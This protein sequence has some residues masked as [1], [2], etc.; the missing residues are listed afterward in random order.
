VTDDRLLG[1]LDLAATLQAGRP[2]S[3]PGLLAEADGGVVVLPMAERLTA[4]MAA[5]LGAVLD[6]REVASERDGIAVRS[7]VRIG[8]LLFDEGIGE[9]ERAPAA[10]LDRL[11]FIV[12]L[13][14]VSVRNVVDSSYRL[15]DVAAARARLASVDG[16]ET[17]AEALCATAMALGIA[18]LRPPLLALRVARAAAALAGRST[19][20][21][22]DAAL[23]GR[24]V[25]APRALLPPAAEPPA[26]TDSDHPPP[27]EQSLESTRQPDSAEERSP[28][29]DKPLAEVVLEAAQ[30]AIPA[31]LLA[32]LRLPEGRRSPARSE[33]RAG[34]LRHSL[35]RGRPLGARRGEPKPGVRL[36]VVETLRAAA[37]WQPL[38]R[39]EG[40]GKRTARIE[41]RRD[42]FRVTRFKQRTETTAVFL[43][44]ASGSA[45][46]HRLAEAKGA[47]ELLLADCYVRRDQV[48]LLAF[49]GR[50]AEL[51]LPPTRSLVRAKRCLAALPGGGGTPL[52]AGIEAAAALAD[53]IRRRGDTPLMILLTDGR[54]N[55]ARDGDA[56]RVRAEQD[57]LSAARRVRAA[58]FMAVLVDTSPRPRPGAERLAAEMGA[59]YLALPHADAAMLSQ[60]VRA[61]VG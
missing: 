35:K 38:R 23:A 17:I 33:G 49:R 50:G 18:S 32:Q 60:A 61:A 21:E 59:R 36:N 10:L 25:L 16:D 6:S 57:A 41:I 14:E 4:A 31:G 37:P 47:V 15:G 52:A 40:E 42:D 46:L 5:R 12:N 8:V 29:P 51:L 7:P 30:A 24:L 53:T 2:V 19:V 58:E 45:A 20:T 44:D 43:V 54:G 48:A 27:S 11:A 1:G 56:D 3:Q 22:A 13:S 55:I 28:P 39:R 9:E 26:E 34:A